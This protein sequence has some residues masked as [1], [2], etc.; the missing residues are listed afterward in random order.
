MH[1]LVYE[2][3]RYQN[4]RYDDKKYEGNVLLLL[5]SVTISI[6][7]LLLLLF[8]PRFLQVNPYITTSRKYE[9]LHAF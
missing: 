9:D 4:A 6:V 3:Y 2:L 7:L 5:V 1:L 8:Y